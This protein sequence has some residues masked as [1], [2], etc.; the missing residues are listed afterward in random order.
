[1]FQERE[2]KNV[3]KICLLLRSFSPAFFQSLTLTLNTYFL[4]PL[5]LEVGTL[6]ESRS[7][8]DF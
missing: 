7:D 8:R 3:G 4:T 2:K 6:A 1:M 5:E